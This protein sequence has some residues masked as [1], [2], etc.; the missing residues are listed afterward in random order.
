MSHKS[1]KEHRR[2][3]LTA[4]AETSADAIHALRSFYF[5]YNDI[6]RLLDAGHYLRGIVQNYLRVMPRNG[7]KCRNR[8]AMAIDDDRLAVPVN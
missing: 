3:G 7:D 1:E 8:E 5:P 4:A 2:R 6:T